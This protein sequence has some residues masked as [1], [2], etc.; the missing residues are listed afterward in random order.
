MESWGRLGRCGGSM[1]RSIAYGRLTF[2]CGVVIA[3]T[4]PTA[5]FGHGGRTNASGCH[6]NRKTGDYHCHG[7]SSGG[8]A[9]ASG[10]Q[11]LYNN[12]GDNRSYYANCSE[13]RAAG[14]APLRRGQRGY[15]PKLDRDGD[16]IA[17]E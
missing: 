8:S 4:L 7:G 15:A 17:C 11:A 16:G 9:K 1:R 13:A 10:P 3:A 14:V 12:G 6:N 2:A 5:S